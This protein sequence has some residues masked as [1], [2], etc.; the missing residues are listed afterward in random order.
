M[1]KATCSILAKPYRII[2]IEQGSTADFSG[3]N[4]RDVQTITVMA[5]LSKEARE[6]TILH[7]SLHVISDELCL[8]L[9]EEQIGALAC[10]LYSAGC[11]IKVLAVK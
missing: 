2:E 1:K 5:G 7:E 10:G 4:N 8:K 3:T 9:T 11:R 6:D